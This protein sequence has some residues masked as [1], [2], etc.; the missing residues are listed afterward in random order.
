M[1][2]VKVQAIVDFETASPFVNRDQISIH[3][4]EINSLAQGEWCWRLLR[5]LVSQ[6]LSFGLSYQISGLR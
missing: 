6:D 2:W 1:A 5:S 4:L 3:A